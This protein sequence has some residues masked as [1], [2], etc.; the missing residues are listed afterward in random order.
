MVTE[1]T[2]F[3]LFGFN[4]YKLKKFNGRAN[5]SQNAHYY[6]NA[7]SVSNTE[8]ILPSQYNTSLATMMSAS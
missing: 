6:S 2:A 4:E 7:Q 5:Y 1:T 8:Y 3:S